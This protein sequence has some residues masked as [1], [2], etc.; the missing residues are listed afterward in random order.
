MPSLCHKVSSNLS[1]R[2]L[3]SALILLTTLCSCRT[4]SDIHR[5]DTLIVAMTSFP[6]NLDPRIGL[7]SA[8]E[9]FHHLIF[10]GLLRKEASGRMVPDL[11]SR[12]ERISPTLYRFYLR[13]NVYFHNGKR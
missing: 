1:H 4:N 7:D 10:N 2:K 9:D 11:C 6:T 13:P 12:F 3:F 8:S 5:T